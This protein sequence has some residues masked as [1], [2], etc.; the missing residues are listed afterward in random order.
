M[1]SPCDIHT[2]EQELEL[3][4]ARVKKMEEK[5]IKFDRQMKEKLSG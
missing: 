3:V 4:R 2:F 1:I 5:Q